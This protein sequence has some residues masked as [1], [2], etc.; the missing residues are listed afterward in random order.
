MVVTRLFKELLVSNLASLVGHMLLIILFLLVAFNTV[1]RSNNFGLL[2]SRRSAQQLKQVKSN[3]ER[4]HKT[5]YRKRKQYEISKYKYNILC[6]FLKKSNYLMQQQQ[7]QQ[8]QQIFLTRLWRFSCLRHIYLSQLGNR[9]THLYFFSY[10]II[11]IL[12]AGNA[13]LFLQSPR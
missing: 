1:P 2:A 11:I 7:Q 10:T 12:K 3:P 8:W 5:K 6:H 4:F 9:G 13:I